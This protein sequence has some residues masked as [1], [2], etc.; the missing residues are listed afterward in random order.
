M[1]RQRW[2]RISYLHPFAGRGRRSVGGG[3]IEERNQLGGDIQCSDKSQIGGGEGGLAVMGRFTETPTGIEYASLNCPIRRVDSVPP[4]SLPLCPALFRIERQR[5][6]RRRIAIKK[7]NVI[8]GIGTRERVSTRTTTIAIM[9]SS[10]IT[11][12]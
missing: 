9:P 7:V 12:R 1:N 6:R 3:S 2:W 5:G 10:C 8:G 4:S 11:R